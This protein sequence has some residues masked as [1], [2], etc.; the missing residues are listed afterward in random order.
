M[1]KTRNP[2]VKLA[3]HSVNYESLK[4]QIRFMEVKNQQTILTTESTFSKF[5]EPKIYEKIL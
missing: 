1:F 5:Y 3:F 4:L 2:I